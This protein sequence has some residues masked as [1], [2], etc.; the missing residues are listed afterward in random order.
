MRTFVRR[1]FR[2]F[3]AL[4]I[5][6]GICSCSSSSGITVAP[7]ATPLAGSGA[8]GALGGAAPLNLSLKF[9]NQSG[10]T[11]PVMVTVPPTSQYLPVVLLSRQVGP[12]ATATLSWNNAIGVFYTEF[13]NPLVGAHVSSSVGVAA[14][15]QTT[16]TWNIDNGTATAASQSTPA[17]PEG[18]LA[19]IPGT[20]N[21][22][23]NPYGMGINYGIGF[24]IGGSPV[25]VTSVVAPATAT[26]FCGNS[27]NTPYIVAVG[28]YT[29][30]TIAAIESPYA[31]VYF[32]SG[33]SATVTFSATGTYS[34]SYP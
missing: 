10:Y 29:Q 34:I 24:T 28:T 27:A 26:T 6:V 16:T 18:C 13:L 23:Q 4:A 12:G 14:S 17:L 20:V 30:G 32:G 9:V 2:P 31:S 8:G 1:L 25:A 22:A 19:V 5:C 33:N 15:A 3:V 11:Q 21:P 7:A